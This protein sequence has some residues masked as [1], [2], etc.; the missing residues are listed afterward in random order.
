MHYLS[1]EQVQGKDMDARSDIFSFGLVLYEMLAG[2][3][4]F[5]GENSAS[6]M[7]AILTSEP[8]PVSEIAVPAALD[9]LLRRC[10]AKDPEERWQTARDLAAELD[11]IASP[12]GDT[13]P[14]AR[15]RERSAWGLKA[16]AAI[17]TAVLLGAAVLA[18]VYLRKTP[19]PPPLVRYSI[20]LPPNTRFVDYGYPVV[21]YPVVSPNGERIAIP[22]APAVGER[23]QIWIYQMSTGEFRPMA[24]SDGAFE[25]TWSPDGGSIV[26][27]ANQKYNRLD[28][29]SGAI[30]AVVEEP[31]YGRP[32]IA[33][34]GSMLVSTQSGLELVATNGQRRP[35]FSRMPNDP[36]DYFPAL[37]PN[38]NH[39]LFV[40]GLFPP[41][42]IWK[43]D[44]DGSAP[45]R[46]FSADSQV[47][48]ADSGHVLFVRGGTLF[49]QLFESRNAVASGPAQSLVNGV[50]RLMGSSLAGFS[51]S[52]NGVLAFR[53]GAATN[54]T[55]LIWRD[56]HG[57]ELGTV[58]QVA[59]YTNPALSPDDKRVAVGIRDL[60]SGK[61]N[62]WVF[63]LVRGTRTP[64]TFD[65][66]D[67]LNPAWS[68]NGTR[69]A[70]SSDRKGMRDIYVT[71]ASGGSQD[72]V[73]FES[74][75]RHKS[76]EDWSAD[77]QFL[78]YS[79]Q[80]KQVVV[81][82]QPYSTTE[83]QHDIYLL[84]LSGEDRRPI[85][86]LATPFREYQVR[87]SPDGRWVAY[88]SNESGRFEV[89]VQP[90]P[91]SGKKYQISNAGGEEPQW[92][93]DG[94]ELFYVAGT[95]VMAAEVRT[96]GAALDPGIPTKLFDVHLGVR[97][98][99][100]LATTKDG[101][102]FLAV[103]PVGED[104]RAP[105]TVILNWQRL[106]DKR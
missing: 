12:L 48:Y 45:V 73:L 83:S 98:R 36:F 66:N 53:P 40:R 16:A 71:S 25:I 79:Q 11:W 102:K 38:S 18:F 58:G 94:K 32:T 106:L 88:C 67:H 37:L 34:N 21:Q 20:P 41:I 93:G 3:R 31:R 80:E 97:A 72:E 82:P 105:F 101:Q 103:E 57:R 84:P 59:D 87:M 8:A 85:T 29:S 6:V 33:P 95:S 61:R 86:F 60:H 96:K 69:I 75:D 91:T 28:L 54:T 7:A 19:P 10:L 47:E 99:N 26:F 70:F 15:R 5:E 68:P 2:R 52:R 22:L 65:P 14:E 9:R 13:T 51:V 23:T 77:G 81:D 64:L 92:R 30:N 27:W 90:F 35:V 4:A 56:R 55:R 62:I 44:L 100:R 1:P 46:L 104:P 50:A 89:Y 76:V 43:G 24:G 78:F 74:K 49:A 39:F 63:D 17:A 42:E